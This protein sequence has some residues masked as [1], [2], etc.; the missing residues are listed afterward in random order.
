MGWF[1]S[2]TCITTCVLLL[3]QSIVDAVPMNE[4]RALVERGTNLTGKFLHITGIYFSS[5]GSGH[6]N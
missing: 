6:L 4:P 3:Q 1:Q 5:I 2:L